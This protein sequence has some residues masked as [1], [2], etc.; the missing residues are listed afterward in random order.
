MRLRARDIRSQADAGGRR[1]AATVRAKRAVGFRALFPCRARCA[2]S[3]PPDS[4]RPALPLLS[5][6]SLGTVPAAGRRRSGAR[7]RQAG[8]RAG[9][10]VQLLIP[11]NTFHTARLLGRGRWFF[12]APAPNGP[13]LFRRT[14]KS[15]ISSNWRRNILISSANCARSRRP[16]RRSNPP[17][18]KR[19]RAITPKVSLCRRL[20]FAA[21]FSHRRSWREAH[22]LT[23]CA[24]LRQI[25]PKNAYNV[26]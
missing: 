18:H 6:R 22:G 3:S 15:A 4:K 9:Q 25:A 23:S 24:I 5:R 1:V 7:R 11:G 12:G 26:R 13:A 19:D 14:S 10:R 21:G 8:L 2:G 16:R 17:L 20:I